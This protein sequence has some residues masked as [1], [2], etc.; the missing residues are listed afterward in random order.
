[1]HK[2]SDD[3]TS[4]QICNLLRELHFISQFLTI[5]SSR[6]VYILFFSF[7]TLGKNLL[8]SCRVRNEGLVSYSYKPA[9]KSFR[10]NGA[11]VKNIQKQLLL[12][13]AFR[14]RCLLKE[15]KTVSIHLLAGTR[16]LPVQLSRFIY[17]VP[18]TLVL[19]DY[20]LRSSSEALLFLGFSSYSTGTRASNDLSD[21]PQKPSSNPSNISRTMGRF[22]TK[23]IPHTNTPS[24]YL[25]F[26]C[27]FSV[28]RNKDG[29]QAARLTIIN[30]NHCLSLYTS[31][32]MRGND[33]GTLFLS[34]RGFFERGKIVGHNTYEARV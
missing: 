12:P 2:R 21:K 7:F 24:E 30:Y 18:R 17:R 16:R 3:R 6:V 23:T 5:S 34:T 25:Q 14:P 10:V 19:L 31:R 9:S 4:T 11:T 1:M 20:S 28:V 13:S 26:F 8:S 27:S 22:V 32:K 33:I 29:W 15:A